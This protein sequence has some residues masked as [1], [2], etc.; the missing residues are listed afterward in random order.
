MKLSSLVKS[1]SAL[2]AVFIYRNQKEAAFFVS[3][4]LDSLLG[5][6]FYTKDLSAQPPADCK[7]SSSDAH[8][9]K[10]MN[11]FAAADC[12]I[13][14]QS[15]FEACVKKWHLSEGDANKLAIMTLKV[16]YLRGVP[17]VVLTASGDITGRFLAK[18]AVGKLTHPSDTGLYNMTDGSVN[19]KQFEILKKYALVNAEGEELI[20][21]SNLNKYLADW[22]KVDKR[23]KDETRLYQFIGKQ[24]NEGEFEIFFKR[25]ITHWL[26]NP[27]TNVMEGCVTLDALKSFLMDSNPM[28]NAV[29]AQV[30]PPPSSTPSLAI[31]DRIINSMVSFAKDVVKECPSYFPP[32]HTC[33]W[34]N[35][36]QGFFKGVKNTVQSEGSAALAYQPVL[37]VLR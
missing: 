17:G 29:K 37:Q 5:R 9:T 23:W 1:T 2:L 28:V 30:L 22:Y 25:S 13:D 35:H 11:T 16:A 26:L 8:L 15:I 33:Y 7:S 32:Q 10:H 14:K 4:L 34:K 24:G 3:V 36:S 19:L 21:Q 12:Y 18:D 27:E 31:G 6:K 20:C